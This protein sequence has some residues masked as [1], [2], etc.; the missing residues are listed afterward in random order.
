MCAHAETHMHAC[1][2]T[3]EVA[4]V[5]TP[6]RLDRYHAIEWQKLED[7]SVTLSHAQG[8]HAGIQRSLK[9]NSKACITSALTGA[10]S[11]LPRE[12]LTVARVPR[13]VC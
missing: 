6:S 2:H 13:N 1:T 12:E 8:A 11:E 7:G 3:R 10:A 9:W 4:E 5:Q